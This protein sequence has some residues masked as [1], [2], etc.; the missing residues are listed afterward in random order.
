MCDEGKG[1]VRLFSQLAIDNDDEFL[2]SEIREL[3][4][5]YLFELIRIVTFTLIRWKFPQQSNNWKCEYS[6]WKWNW[7]CIRR[8]NSNKR[9]Q[10]KC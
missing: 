9:V 5:L 1:L 3:F 8:C 10:F 6:N 2:N 7:Y 4:T